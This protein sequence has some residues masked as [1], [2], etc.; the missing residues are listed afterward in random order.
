MIIRDRNGVVVEVTPEWKSDS[1]RVNF[2]Y[3][4]REVHL[5]PEEADKLAQQLQE[6][7]RKVREFTARA[8]TKEKP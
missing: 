4:T 5:L 7:A 3:Y 6:M 8:G 1:V 2:G